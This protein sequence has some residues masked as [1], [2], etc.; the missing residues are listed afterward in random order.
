MSPWRLHAGARIG[1]WRDAESGSH[2][3]HALRAAG[4]HCAAVWAAGSGA[5]LGA[6]LIVARR[7]GMP[8]MHAA[9]PVPL[10]ALPY[11]AALLDVVMP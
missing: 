6:V 1:V 7:A 2:A 9:A 11:V 5:V 8:N 3:R 10:M 4:R